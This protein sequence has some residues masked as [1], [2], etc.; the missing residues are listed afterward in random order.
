MLI[1]LVFKFSFGALAF[2][3]LLFLIV[4]LFFG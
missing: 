4:A 3:I 2:I 1:E